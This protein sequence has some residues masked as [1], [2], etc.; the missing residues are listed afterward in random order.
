LG[1]VRQATTASDLLTSF[2]DSSLKPGYVLDDNLLFFDGALVIPS[3]DFQLQIL[4]TPHKLYRLLKPLPIPT[5][6]WH[7]VSLDFVFGLPLS[8]GFNSILVVKDQFSKR[9]HYLPCLTT[10]NAPQTADLFF[11]EIFRLHGLPKTIV[12]DRGP[13]FASKFWK[14]LFEALGVDIHHFT[15]FRPVTD[16]STKVTNQVMEL[17]GLRC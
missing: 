9:A 8:S 5:E 16:G 6:C 17:L 13:Q 15:A 14:R 1:D 2:H 3:K 12:S 4:A 11:R 7:D 10:I